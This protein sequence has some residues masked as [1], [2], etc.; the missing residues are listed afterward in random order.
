MADVRTTE[1]QTYLSVLVGV[2]LLAG[3][4]IA[5]RYS[6]L[7]FHSLA[8]MAS[9]FVACGIFIVAWN[10][11]RFLDNSYLLL[12]GISFLFVG[13]LDLVHTLAYKGMGVFP[14]YDANLSTQLWI[15]ARYTE[16]VAFLVAPVLLGK[17]VKA[18]PIF[19][20]YAL[21][22]SLLLV[23][24]FAL[25]IFPVCFIEGEGLTTFKITSEYVICLLL[26]ISAGMLLSK[27]N[28]F[29]P[30]VWRLLV[31][32]IAV[33]VCSELAFT[34]YVDVYGPANL[35][36]H[37][38]KVVSFYLVYIGIV[39]TG[40]SKPFGLIL[41]NVEQHY[42]TMADF[43]YDWEYWE[44][45]EGKIEYVSPS[46]ERITGYRP[47]EFIDE[48]GLLGEIVHPEDSNVWAKHRGEAHKELKPR[49]VEFRIL[50]SDGDVRWIDHACQP[51]T[52]D[53]GEFLGFRASNRDITMRKQTEEETRKLRE[54]LAHVTR[55]ATL[56]EL[57]ASLAHELNQPLAAILSNA[58]AAQR[59]LDKEEPS[60]DDV[61]EALA[62]IIGD[63]RRA[64]EIIRR[65]RALLG[66]GDLQRAP[67]DVDEIV[68]ETVSVMRSE[69]IV[70]NISLNVF[71]ADDLPL[72]SGDRVQLQ[73]VILNLMI[74]AVEAMRDVA[75]D[76]REIS[77]RTSRE[78]SERIEIAVED[79]GV[80][81][82]QYHM[83]RM[84]EPLFTTKDN[85]LG[86]GL[87]ICRSIVEAHGG[88]LWAGNNPER[89]ATFHVVLPAGKERSE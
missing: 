28:H 38:L 63:G 84:F 73:Q 2:L 10:S 72:V 7:L 23:S 85:G 29:D 19:A 44:R 31:A 54:H 52:T 47:Q 71:L 43:T 39:E 56:G 87:S 55:V 57:S 65:L 61:R 22:F 33:K 1:R 62:D 53:E 88:R 76:E 78:D 5:S 37:F 14:G 45:P 40:L 32:S 51:V 75:A 21:V 35:V 25:G 42:R 89:G 16:S 79:R 15:A 41:R 60:V 34:L 59:F 18:G 77:I 27:R 48:P 46:C 3:L 68:R 26:A 74:N 4:Y 12:L 13:G 49:H 80:G 86:M 11:R 50:R 83:E 69:A 17:K 67:L 58:Q 30:R 8:E 9:I 6:Y 24:I 66:K 81:I 70:K 36:G 64:G 20:G 82:D